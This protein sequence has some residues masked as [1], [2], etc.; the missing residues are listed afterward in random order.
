MS[1][2]AIGPH[3]LLH[4]VQ[5]ALIRF[6]A[7]LGDVGLVPFSLLVPVLEACSP[8][9]LSHIEDETRKGIGKRSLTSLTWPLWYHH[10]MAPQM[11]RLGTCPPPERYPLLEGGGQE[12]GNGAKNYLATESVPMADWRRIYEEMM[13]QVREQ[14]EASVQRAKEAFGSQ[15]RQQAERVPQIIAPLPARRTRGVGTTTEGKKAIFKEGLGPKERLMKKLGMRGATGGGSSSRPSQSLPA[16]CTHRNFAKGRG[17]K[18][19]RALKSRLTSSI[20]KNA[21][22]SYNAQLMESDMFDNIP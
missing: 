6:K 9:E 4:I 7:Y 5:T 13:K 16:A 2:T 12:E 22:P 3:S 10:C 17:A 1:D 19:F 18:G 8:T 21:S 15:R 11:A 14:R 20:K